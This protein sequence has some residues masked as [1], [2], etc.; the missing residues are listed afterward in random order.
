MMSS[1]T[2]ALLLTI[3]WSQAVAMRSNRDVVVRNVWF[4]SARSRPGS[5]RERVLYEDVDTYDY[6]PKKAEA[7]LDQPDISGPNG[8]RLKIIYDIARSG[9][10]YLG[11]GVL[12]QQ[13][14]ALAQSNC[15]RR[16]P[17]ISAADDTT[18]I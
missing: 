17:H 4:G 1:T 12:K 16:T 13:L 3:R 10:E 2:S 5:R 6:D 9:A 11:S 7:L 8:T 15:G 14:A 18:M